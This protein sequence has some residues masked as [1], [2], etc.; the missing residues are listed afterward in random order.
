MKNKINKTTGFTLIELL[1][2]MVIIGLIATATTVTFGNFSSTQKMTITR[3]NLHT[4]LA[5][6]KSK[7]LSQVVDKCPESVGA[8]LGYQVSFNASSNDYTLMEL[9]DD[10]DGIDPP[11]PYNVRTTSL[12]DGI[13]FTAAPIIRFN[14][15]T[16]GSIGDET[17]TITNGDSTLDKS[18]SVSLSGIIH[19]VE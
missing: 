2:V 19:N 13:F 4:A 17:V 11:V 15:L 16:G 5:E 1:I 8:L 14:V 3:D 9:C 18:I 6:A 12:P 10:S 7:S